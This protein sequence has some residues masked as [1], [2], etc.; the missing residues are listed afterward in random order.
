MDNAQDPETELRNLRLLV[1]AS[2]DALVITDMGGRVTLWNRAAEQL[3]GYTE[4]EA[5]GKLLSHLIVPP[6]KAAEFSDLTW[7]VQHEGKVIPDLET[8]GLDKNG[9]LID[10]ILTLSPLWDAQRITGICAATKH[11]IHNTFSGGKEKLKESNEILGRLVVEGS[12][13]LHEQTE[14]IKRIL[15]NVPDTILIFNLPGLDVTFCSPSVR[16]LTGYSPEEIRRGGLVKFIY[17]DDWGEQKARMETLSRLREVEQSEHRISHRNGTIRWVRTRRSILKRDAPGTPDQV[18]TI[19]HDITEAKLAAEEKKAELR[20]KLHERN[21]YLE[22]IQ[23]NSVDIITACDKEY[24][25]TIWNRAAE[26]HYRIKREDVLGKY[27]FDVFPDYREKYSPLLERAF[28]G[29]KVHIPE[30]ERNGRDEWSELYVIPLRDESGNVEGILSIIHDIT[31]RIRSDREIREQSHF[32]TQITETVPDILNVY[33]LDIQRV[34]YSNRELLA[35][36]G[37]DV[38]D[39]QNLTLEKLLEPLHEDD[40][41]KMKNFMQRILSAADNDIIE[42]EFRAYD[43]HRQV[44]WFHTRASVFKRNKKGVPVQY[45]SVT[46]NIT[47][48]KAALK[49]LIEAEK[50]AVTGELARMMAHDVRNPLTSVNLAVEILRGKLKNSGDLLSYTDIIVRNNKRINQLIIQLLSATRPIESS[51]Q[52]I[53]LSVLVDEAIALVADRAVLDRKNIKTNYDPACEIMV[54][55]DSVR[56]ALLNLI[57]NAVEAIKPDTGEI[58]IQTWMEESRC[59][60]SISDNGPGIDKRLLAHVFDPFHTTKPS[61]IGLGLATART[62]IRSNKGMIEVDSSPDTGTTFIIGFPAIDHPAG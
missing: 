48:N 16:E 9:R 15:D 62:L 2:H 27:Y 57:L 12:V 49:A 40:R 61:G 22:S 17:K 44:N 7:H 23:D 6:H 56:I 60:L 29:E 4:Q 11:I 52:R 28:S 19:I 39:T 24:R 13:A 20:Q 51:A 46:Q 8:Q 18:I 55:K 36:L 32:I 47:E 53:Y 35:T 10:V 3:Y 38:T 14:Y 58:T 33:D 41:S 1:D 31:Q 25:F 45:I 54:N 37:Y 43:S 26:E 21:I 34:I 42:V 50:L 59:F 5:L 30:I